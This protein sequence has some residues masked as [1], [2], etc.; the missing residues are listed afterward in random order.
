ML[1]G[2][3][4]SVQSFGV[5][6]ND[7]AELLPGIVG[8]FVLVAVVVAIL[9]GLVWLPLRIWRRSVQR[10]GYP[11]LKVYLRE[12]PQTPEKKLDAVELTLKGLVICIMGLIFPPLSLVGL[13]PF[14]YGARKLAAM[15]LVNTDAEANRRTGQS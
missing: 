9:I 1:C 8:G 10:R 4:L 6:S 3:T 5:R 2:T 11:E 13:V 12:V 15:T 7:I 14:Y